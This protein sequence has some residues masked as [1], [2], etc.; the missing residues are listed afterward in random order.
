[1]NDYDGN[2]VPRFVE[3][4]NSESN[5]NVFLEL[6]ST[7][8]DLKKDRRE[9]DV[10]Y[11]NRNMK[12]VIG[13]VEEEW[14][15]EGQCGMD[16]TKTVTCNSRIPRN[17]ANRIE[18]MFCGIIPR[19]PDDLSLLGRKMAYREIARDGEIE[20]KR[21]DGLEDIKLISNDF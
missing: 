13:K 1:M 20:K 7:D 4:F 6:V 9:F 5:G 18:A 14:T 3:D 8:S 16:Y 19:F 10:V 15:Y 12:A 21:L 2:P 11:S 17:M